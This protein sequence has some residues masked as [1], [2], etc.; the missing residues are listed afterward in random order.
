[1]MSKKYKYNNTLNATSVPSRFDLYKEGNVLTIDKDGYVV[2][3]EPQGGSGPTGDV[4][5]PSQVKNKPQI[6]GVELVG[7]KTAE[8]LGL[9]SLDTFT[10]ETQTINS[11]LSNFKNYV[12][13]ALTKKED[14]LDLKLNE[15]VKVELSNGA[16]NI[17]IT[18]I[19]KPINFN[20]ELKVGGVDVA[21]K[22]DLVAQSINSTTTNIKIGNDLAANRLVIEN[23]DGETNI[24]SINNRE[25]GINN[26]Y[27]INNDNTDTIDITSGYSS[28]KIQGLDI[29]IKSGN[30]EA[31]ISFSNNG[32][33]LLNG[34]KILTE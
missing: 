32:D 16:N 3:K 27:V 28:L 20:Q 14:E 18:G 8:A 12:D 1:M 23:T 19:G 33:L 21:T 10:K 30:N 6:D 22:Q 4:D 26:L 17:Q 2:Q 31:L 34:K 7:N 24:T 11:N 29:V 15:N 25:I 9:T 5:Y 13:S